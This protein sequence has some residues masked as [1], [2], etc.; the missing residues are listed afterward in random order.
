MEEIKK[1]KEQGFSF[2]IVLIIVIVGVAIGVIVYILN[3]NQ[4]QTDNEVSNNGILQTLKEKVSPS[5][6]AEETKSQTMPVSPKPTSSQSSETPSAKAN[7]SQEGA[8][9]A[10]DDGWVLLW[11]EPGR[12]A[13][14]VRVKFN[15]QSGC[16]LG[17]EG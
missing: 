7:F 6:P 17:G 1:T 16:Y 11:D 2:I 4:S 8:L 3:N 15:N 13:L 14:N 9:F 12:L 10:K 5:K